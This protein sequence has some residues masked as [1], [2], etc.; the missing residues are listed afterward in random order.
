MTEHP[1]LIQLSMDVAH[2]FNTVSNLSYNWKPENFRRPTA[3]NKPNSRYSP[4]KEKFHYDSHTRTDFVNHGAR[5]RTEAVHQPELRKSS[6]KVADTSTYKEA[7]KSG[8]T[9]R[10]QIHGEPQATNLKLPTPDRKFDASS[11]MRSDFTR[12]TSEKRRPFKPT[13]STHGNGG[14]VAKATEYNETFLPKQ[15]QPCMFSELMKE[16]RA[17]NVLSQSAEIAAI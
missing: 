17:A 2:D 7:F 14:L 12:F 6:A 8:A 3:S 11:T 15:N 10:R 13:T 9:S 1:S 4:P 16:N 5:P